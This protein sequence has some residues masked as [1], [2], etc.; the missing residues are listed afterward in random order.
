MNYISTLSADLRYNFL[1]LFMDAKDLDCYLIAQGLSNLVTDASEGLLWA[2]SQGCLIL[3]CH[4]KRE[5]QSFFN[6]KSS[7]YLCYG[8]SSL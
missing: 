6:Q 5:P 1:I 7:Y 2:A 8:Y 3:V 4:R